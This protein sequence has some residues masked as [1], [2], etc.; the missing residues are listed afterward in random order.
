MNNI[1]VLFKKL[2]S[3]QYSG[4]KRRNNERSLPVARS[5]IL[6][7]LSVESFNLTYWATNRFFRVPSCSIMPW[8]CHNMT[9][10]PELCHTVAFFLP[11]GMPRIT[12]HYLSEFCQ[13]F[14]SFIKVYTSK[15]ATVVI[16][17]LVAVA[18]EQS[19]SFLENPWGR[20]QNK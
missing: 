15:V 20:T 4:K 17:R 12:L 6:P 16:S 10:L 3:Q 8:L 5:S 7:I 9:L 2:I 11:Q 14:F 13:Q 1:K 19:L 18:C